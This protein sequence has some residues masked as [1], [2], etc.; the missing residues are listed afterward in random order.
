MTHF[1]DIAFINEE[2]TGSINEEAIGVINEAAIGAIIGP[3]NSPLCF[4]I[5]CFTVSVA[6][7]IYRPD[8][9]SDSTISVISSIS[10][11]EMNK[12][13]L[14]PAPTT[15]CP[16]ILLSYVSN[17]DEIILVAIFLNKKSLAKGTARSNNTFLA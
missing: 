15:P 4:L 6:P 16:L 8:F 9:S 10:S 2:A 12:V 14:F 3:V 11:F 1:P 5:P 17:T 13:N 7:S